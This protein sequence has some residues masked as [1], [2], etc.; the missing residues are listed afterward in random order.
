MLENN[1][2]IFVFSNGST[3]IYPDNKL[4][5]FK[6]K[7]PISMEEKQKYQ[8]AVQ[9]ICLSQNFRRVLSPPSSNQC[10]I[11]VFLKKDDLSE[12]SIV[13]GY[14]HILREECLASKTFTF[15]E[16]NSSTM[17]QIKTF[18]TEINYFISF[19]TKTDY[20]NHFCFEG[21][22]E[23]L[24]TIRNQT[25]KKNLYIALHPVTI[26]SF[27]IPKPSIINSLPEIIHKQERV[28][29]D[30][31][32]NNFL[33][34]Y[35]QGEYNEE[36]LS[37]Q[38]NIRKL[39]I[40]GF[41][42][43]CFK[44]TEDIAT[45]VRGTR[46]MKE[47]K[48]SPEFIRINCPQIEE[49]IFDN[50]YTRDIICFT[51]E[52]NETQTHFYQ[53]FKKKQYVSLEN[54]ILDSLEIKILDEN[55]IPLQL[56]PDVPTFVHLKIRRMPYYQDEVINLHIS[57]KP[58]E[59]YEDN[60]P[61]HFKVKLP[62]DLYVDASYKIAL[63]SI[64]YP[65]KFATYPNDEYCLYVCPITYES[66][67]SYTLHDNSTFTIDNPNAYGLK[68]DRDT[69]YSLEL[70]ICAIDNFLSY[71][72][73]GSVK[74]NRN[75]KTISIL[76]ENNHT[77]ENGRLMRTD[78]LIIFI[79]KPLLKILGYSYK[80]TFEDDHTFNY[81]SKIVLRPCNECEVIKT[82]NNSFLLYYNYEK[83]VPFHMVRNGMLENNIPNQ[84]MKITGPDIAIVFNGTPNLRYLHPKYLIIY[85]NILNPSLIGGDFSKILK[86]VPVKYTESSFHIE[87]MENK[88][89]ITLQN[90]VL[91][92]LEF[93]IRTHDGSF[94]RYP[95]SSN[96]LLNL[97]LTNQR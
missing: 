39:R 7:F 10:N 56:L 89:Y 16:S 9:G 36:I 74:E 82:E 22:Q 77:N 95:E 79:S 35:I 62:Q 96:V 26:K 4:T 73:I 86:V 27:N 30:I 2:S 14:Y 90:N 87:E 23:N 38:P 68:L 78:E 83:Y 84:G 32:K 13:N 93:E 88:D 18:F 54:T 50:G 51:P 76:I 61:H 12:F 65:C 3:E 8:I 64:N 40:N 47:N 1:D 75:D 60:K 41:D 49:Q 71:L 85:S 67:F 11:I 66:N 63:T 52:L 37:Y 17:E 25:R 33:N 45:N 6:N 42:Y 24:L 43:Y 21:R 19:V 34:F 15:D 72:N 69:N 5:N 57:S 44:I 29:L 53:E 97:E 55:N 28:K 48:F 80:E 20:A 59:E 46:N 31:V 70:I 94:V 81:S 58:R 91:H 92:I